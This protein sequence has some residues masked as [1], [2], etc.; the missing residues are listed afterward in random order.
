MVFNTMQRILTSMQCS[1][2]EKLYAD[3]TPKNYNQREPHPQASPQ[4]SESSEYASDT[5]DGYNMSKHRKSVDKGSSNI[6][7]KV[8]FSDETPSTASTL[9]KYAGIR[10]TMSMPSVAYTS[11]SIYHDPSRNGAYNPDPPRNGAYNL[12]LPRNG[13][14]N[15]DQPENGAYNPDPPGNATYNPDPTRNAAY[16]PDPPRNAAYNPD[17]PRNGAYNPDSGSVS[18]YEGSSAAPRNP[19]PPPDKESRYLTYA[20]KLNPHGSGYDP[21]TPYQQSTT[22]YASVKTSFQELS[23]VPFLA[24]D[25]L[26]TY[27]QKGSNLKEEIFL[28]NNGNKPKESYTPAETYYIKESYPAQFSKVT[29]SYY[30]N[31]SINQGEDIM[32]VNDHKNQQTESY[33]TKTNL[34]KS[35]YSSKYAESYKTQPKEFYVTPNKNQPTTSYSSKDTNEHE[36]SHTSRNGYQP[37][38]PFSNDDD[39]RQSDPYYQ[40]ETATYSND[41]YKYKESN[42]QNDPN[43]LSN[44][45]SQSPK[46]S[47]ESKRR[48]NFS[49]EIGYSGKESYAGFQESDGSMQLTNNYSNSTK[50]ISLTKKPEHTG[51]LLYQV[52]VAYPVPDT[53]YP[54]Q[55]YNYID[56][57]RKLNSSSAYNTKTT[58]SSTEV[59]S[60]TEGYQ[61]KNVQQENEY[62]QHA[63]GTPRNLRTSGELHQVK[64]SHT[65]R[66]DTYPNGASGPPSSYYQLNGDSR[67]YDAAIDLNRRQDFRKPQPEHFN[68]AEGKQPTNA[69]TQVDSSFPSDNFHARGNPTDVFLLKSDQGTNRVFQNENINQLRNKRISSNELRDDQPTEQY[70]FTTTAP[71]K[72]NFPSAGTAQY[73]FSVK[74]TNV[75]SEETFKKNNALQ[76]DKYRPTEY[77]STVGNFPTETTYRPRYERML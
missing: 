10:E 26:K 8:N 71:N 66:V 18:K 35:L 13:A 47:Y 51:R 34:P 62:A 32:H 31:I 14:Y 17:P 5:S 41:P 15:L 40:K 7:V 4:K 64:E 21:T 58:D 27:P 68:P 22:T 11:T 39:F 25:S 19:Y 44:M 53:I 56:V 50:E 73:A 72:S 38:E 61:S 46:D 43:K 3:N 20:K 67:G 1:M 28:D 36:Y 54:T 49:E 52:P 12:D 63:Y 57:S 45:Y 23:T 76:E 6:F 24:E 55:Q 30:L 77:T 33:S 48:F 75:K 69:K 65:S 59:Y 16:N 60:V 2:Q 29:D 9:S 37:K 70:A 42:L 74:N